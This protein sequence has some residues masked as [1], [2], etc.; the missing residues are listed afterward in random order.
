ME[1]EIKVRGYHTDIYKHVNNARFLEF[2]E[3]G[4][5][6]LF[7]DYLD[8]DEFT[9]GEYAFYVVNINISYKDQA[10]VNDVLIIKSGMLRFGNKSAAFKQQV[11]NKETK[12]LIIDSDVTFVVVDNTGK[13]V[14]IEGKV[15]EM[16][17]KIPQFK[18]V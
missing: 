15:K 7:E 12:S 3:E 2:L 14:K 16:L 18:G 11:I 9:K 1:P 4:R 17:N 5:W 10:N 8:P 13:P 6:Q